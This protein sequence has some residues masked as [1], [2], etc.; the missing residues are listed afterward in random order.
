LFALLIFAAII[1]TQQDRK[2]SDHALSQE[3][4]TCHDHW[5]LCKDNSD[6]VNNWSGATGAQAACH[7]LAKD[8]G[9]YGAPSLSWLMSFTFFANGNNYI[10]NG[11][12]LAGDHDAEFKNQYGGVERI[13]LHCT[14]DLHCHDNNPNNDLRCVTNIWSPDHPELVQFRKRDWR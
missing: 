11:E 6:L 8:T 1:S 14:F 12:Y 3:V 9:R 7:T 4:N 10:E 5:R 13:T 2:I